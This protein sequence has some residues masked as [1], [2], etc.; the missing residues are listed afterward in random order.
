MLDAEHPGVVDPDVRLLRGGE[1]AEGVLEELELVAL[2]DEGELRRGAGV[3]LR[4]RHGGVDVLILHHWSDGELLERV[5]GGR[6]VDAERPDGAFCCEAQ[7]AVIER[8]CERER[9]GGGTRV[10]GEL[11][12]RVVEAR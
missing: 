10:T 9:N 2:R 1:D 8:P 6:D 3:V 5:G 11:D 12:E 4:L 7:E